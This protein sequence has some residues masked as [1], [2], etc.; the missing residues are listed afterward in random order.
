VG[1]SE[2]IG[3]VSDGM[4]QFAQCD[5]LVSALFKALSSVWGLAAHIQCL[6]VKLSFAYLVSIIEVVDCN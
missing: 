3:H 1:H 5:F 2:N 4:G 6:P